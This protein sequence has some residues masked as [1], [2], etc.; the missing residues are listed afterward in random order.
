MRIKGLRL[1]ATTIGAVVTDCTLSKPELHRLSIAAH[2][3]L[4]RAVLPAH[5]PFDGDTMF[6]A[7]TGKRESNGAA[8]LM[9][10]CHLATLVTARAIARGVFEAV[11]LPMR[12]RS[13][14]GVT[15]G[16]ILSPPW[17]GRK[18]FR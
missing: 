5:L 10:L 12:M 6:A 2:D 8:D 4:A 16:V 14:P 1:T 3:G 15:G 17:W 13:R 7:S 9:E 18:R 11:A